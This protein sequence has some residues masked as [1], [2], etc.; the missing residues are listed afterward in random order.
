MPGHVIPQPP[1]LSA[2]F[3]VSM[4]APLQHELPTRVLQQVVPQATSPAKVEQH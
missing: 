2:S 3:D 1:Q 4:H